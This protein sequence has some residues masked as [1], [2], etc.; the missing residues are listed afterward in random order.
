[1][2]EAEGAVAEKA[3]CLGDK[4]AVAVQCPDGSRL[5]VLSIDQM[6]VSLETTWYMP[7]EVN[8]LSQF[9]YLNK[10]F[11]LVGSLS[12]EGPVL[13]VYSVDGELVVSRLIGP[14][15]GV[16]YHYEFLDYKPMS[17]AL[18]AQEKSPMQRKP[19]MPSSV[20][21]W[22]ARPKKLWILLVARDLAIC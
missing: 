17:N 19:W 13:S 20:L 4:V 11:V 22:S 21:V 12:G 14:E 1:M 5:H 10:Q 9:R 8:C 3:Y 7:G 2:T 18:L 16:F 6:D 15:I